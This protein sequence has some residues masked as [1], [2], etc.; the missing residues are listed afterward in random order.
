VPLNDFVQEQRTFVGET[1]HVY[2]HRGGVKG[3]VLMHEIPGITPQ[4]AE[5]ADRLVAAG[6][7]VAM[8]SLFG[9]DGAASTKVLD[10]EMALKLCVNREFNVFAANGSS[11]IVDW[12]RALCV[13]FHKECGGDGIGAVGLCITGGFALSLTVGTGGVVRAPVMSEPSLPFALPKTS[14][15]AAIHLTEAE[16]E[17][18]AQ[19]GPPAVALRFTSDWI[20]EKER[21]DTYQALLGGR[22]MRIEITSPDPANNIPADAHSVLTNDFQDT[23]N[24]PTRLALDRVIAFLHANL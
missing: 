22:L 5:L 4:V 19:G 11:P 17:Q 9:N 1:R 2:Y 8:P 10:A 23:P 21:L 20:C 6:F 15:E 14:N 24:H 18:V 7:S 12:L 13:D 16:H 3:V